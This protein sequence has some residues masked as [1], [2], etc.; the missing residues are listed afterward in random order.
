MNSNPVF[1]LIQTARW[2]RAWFP[3]T[4]RVASALAAIS[5]ALVLVS[6]PAAMG[7]SVDDEVGTPASIELAQAFTS[8]LNAHDVDRVVDMFTE[9]DAGA[10]VT[11]DAYAW[12][13]FEIRLWAQRQALQRVHVSAHDFQ[14][15]ERGAAWNADVFR[16]DWQI[17]GVSLLPVSNTIWVHD[18]KIANFTSILRDPR[19]ARLLSSL[20]EPTWGIQR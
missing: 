4:V 19:D 12:T 10:T 9:D 2:R 5:I 8:A 11:A 6:V 16:N 1:T 3:H 17:W 14:V 7:A 15:I 13:K 18:G 20:W